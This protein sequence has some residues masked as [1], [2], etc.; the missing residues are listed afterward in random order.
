[1]WLH[2][3]GEENNR[4]PNL[5]RTVLP[6]GIRLVVPFAP[7]I[8]L[9]AAEDEERRSWFDVHHVTLSASERIVEDSRGLNESFARLK[10][11]LDSESSILPS[12]RIVLGGFTHGAAMAVHAALRYDKP[13]AGVVSV[14]GYAPLIDELPTRINAANA[15]TPILAYQAKND[16]LVR[17][18]F[19]AGRWRALE[20]LG[21]PVEQ[22]VGKMRLGPETVD[23]L[24]HMQD[25]WLARVR[26]AAA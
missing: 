16:E 17:S 9:T 25:W 19:A 24:V 1:M 10:V 26:S 6:P 23:I 18:D 8:P 7:S 13:L 12:K 11:L 20:A 5:W 22:R 21:V 2:D 4:T 3:V 14:C 15:K